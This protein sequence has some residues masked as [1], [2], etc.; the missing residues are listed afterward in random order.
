MST[1]F[2]PQTDGQTERVNALVEQYIRGYCNYQQDNWVELLTMAEFSYNNTMCSSTGLTPFFAIYG[3]HPRYQ[4]FLNPEIKLP[5]PAELKQFANTLESL[6]EYLRNEMSWAHAVYSEQANK[7]Q[8]PAPRFE[9]G[10]EVWLLR[11][12]IKTIR[13]SAKLDYKHLGKF[14]I[15][16]K[17][18]SHAYKLELPDTMKVH[19]VFHVSLLEPTVS[20]PLPGQLQPPPPPMIIDDSDEPEYEVDEIVD[21]KLVR[22]NKTLKYLV[23]WVRY[24]DLT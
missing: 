24:S 16:K 3:E 1:S 4:V 20:D 21:S 12:N 9:V 15:L 6:N 7:H 5:P 17:V 23:R 10:D 14:K 13:P 11:K 2:H 22:R 8:V 19:P 18:S